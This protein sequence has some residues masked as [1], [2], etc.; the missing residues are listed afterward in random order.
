MYMYLRRSIF[1]AVD[2]RWTGLDWTGLDWTGT[3]DWTESAISIVFA[4][5]QTF[6]RA[7]AIHKRLHYRLY[8][9]E[10]VGS[11]HECVDSLHERVDSPRA[12]I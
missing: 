9:Q 3:V 7:G 12:D 2:N 5:A 10:H 1:L 4:H 8:R 6:R 11:L